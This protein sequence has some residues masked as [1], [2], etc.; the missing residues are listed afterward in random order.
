MTSSRCI[1]LPLPSPLFLL[2]KPNTHSPGHHLQF[3]LKMVL[4][5]SKCARSLDKIGHHSR[6]HDHLHLPDWSL[7]C[8]CS[9]FELDL[10]TGKVIRLEISSDLLSFSGK[11]ELN[12]TMHLEFRTALSPM[13]SEFQVTWTFTTGWK[14]ILMCKNVVTHKLTMTASCPT[15]LNLWCSINKT[16]HSRSLF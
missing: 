4:V 9:R 16:T 15:T 7:P 10:Q 5:W 8:F 13:L 3:E 12:S 11:S 14:I 1:F 2:F 6:L